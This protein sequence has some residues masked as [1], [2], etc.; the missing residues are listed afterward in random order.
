MKSFLFFI[1]FTAGTYSILTAQK[2]LT[3]GYLPGVYNSEFSSAFGQQVQVGLT[4]KTNKLGIIPSKIFNL[5]VIRQINLSYLYT[6]VNEKEYSAI[7]LPLTMG[8]GFPLTDKKS[9]PPL[10]GLMS[11]FE[12]IYPLI[13]H[14]NDPVHGNVSIGYFFRVNLHEKLSLNLSAQYGHILG[15]SSIKNF[16]SSGIRLGYRITRI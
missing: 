8:V 6:K 15:T 16:F 4:I 5:H 2:E 7:S 12:T 11:G 1:L 9:N 14:T 10:L 13:S 3:I